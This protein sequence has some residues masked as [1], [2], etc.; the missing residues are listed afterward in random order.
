MG[1]NDLKNKLKMFSVNKRRRFIASD[2][3][4]AYVNII[5]TTLHDRLLK[6]PHNNLPVLLHYEFQISFCNRTL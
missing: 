2:R 1:D 6:H 4:N 5:S 3:I